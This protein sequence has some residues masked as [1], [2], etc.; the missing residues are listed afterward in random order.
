MA[1]NILGTIVDRIMLFWHDVNTFQ[2]KYLAFKVDFGVG[3]VQKITIA[4]TVFVQNSFCSDLAFSFS[5][6][7][8]R[9]LLSAKNNPFL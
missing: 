5:A 6:A 2:A 7:V 8:M 4:L 1:L 9:L 3:T